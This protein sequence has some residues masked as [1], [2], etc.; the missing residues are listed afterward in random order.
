[1]MKSKEL[2]DVDQFNWLDN[3]VPKYDSR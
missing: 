2:P 3:V 1:M